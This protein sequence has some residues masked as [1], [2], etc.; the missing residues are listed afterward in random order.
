MLILSNVAKLY[1]GTSA[2]KG[3][4]HEGVDLFLEDGRI[5]DRKPHDS[6]LA[7]GDQHQVVDCTGQTVVPGI[8]D[9][10]GHVTVL[11]LT[12]G[13][14]EKTNSPAELLYVEKILYA[15]LV[16]GG[17]HHD[18]R[19]R[20]GDA[21][22]EAPRGRGRHDRPSAEGRDLHAVD[23]GRPRRLPRTRS[24]PCGGVERCGRRPQAV[25]PASS[26]VPGS[27]G[28]ACVRSRHRGADL[29]KLCTS[30]GVA[31]PG[32]KLEHRD[33]TAEEIR[34]ICDEAEARGLR[35]AAHAHSQSGIR[36]AI[37][38]G[39]HDIQHISY[40]DE[41]LV[42]MAY[43]RGCTVTPTSWVVNALPSAE[44]LSDF[45]MEKARQVAEVHQRAV[46]FARSGGLKILAG[47]DPVLP[48]MHGRNYMEIVHLVRD[49][50][51]P[52]QAWYGATGL[53]AEE[54]GQTDTGTL[55]P[56][57]RA[58]LLVCDRD[59]I[60]DP[61]AAR[62]RRDHRGREGR[63]GVPRRD[64][65]NSPANVRVDGTKRARVT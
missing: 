32:D 13:D 21:S 64:R 22:H 30:P 23:D 29:I 33:F 19:R 63:R 12:A 26:T 11:G 6:P 62:S 2:A 16:D 7:A 17:V 41:E 39:V 60:A 44:G 55:K 46:A 18:A 9:A 24:L 15:T 53:A 51:D 42:E 49:G 47:T 43:V 57:Q 20:R 52:L 54:I 40:M 14:R 3:A 25:R 10:H 65:R 50:L 58:D 35:V 38:N 61:E 31:S 48:G 1:D 34:A 45:V 27:A 8:V 5:R 59:V 56:G 4:V 28:S 36:L 37:E